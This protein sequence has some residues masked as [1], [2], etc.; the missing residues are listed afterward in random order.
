MAAPADASDLH[1]S[2]DGN[3]LTYVSR[4]GRSKQFWS[5]PVADGPAVRIGE[6][7]PDDVLNVNWSSD[8][9]RI[10]YLRR[11]IKVELALL[12]NLE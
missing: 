12:T 5:E 8:A 10:V 4:S 1:W 3:S 7:L 2:L 6:P 9:S 11:E